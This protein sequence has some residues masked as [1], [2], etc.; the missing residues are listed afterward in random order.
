MIGGIVKYFRFSWNEVL[1]G[2][3][4]S[5]VLMLSATTPSFD[6]DKENGKEKGG[7]WP[8]KIDEEKVEEFFNFKPR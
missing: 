8:I 4:W 3:S 6:N 7:T 1:W 5:N 2:M